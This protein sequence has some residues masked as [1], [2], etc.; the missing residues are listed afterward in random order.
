M[1]SLPTGV[2]F[3]IGKQRYQ[4][5]GLTHS[6]ETPGGYRECKFSLSS[7]DGAQ[8]QWD[9][10]LVIYDSTWSRYP[11]VGHIATVH[12]TGLCFDFTAV[13]ST[14]LRVIKST[15]GAGSPSHPSGVYAGRIYKAG[16]PM[17]STI[18]DALGLCE[19]VFNGA[20]VDPGL[21]YASDSVNVAGYTAEQLWNYVSSLMTGLATPYQWHIRGL[22]GLQV[23]DIAYADAAARYRVKLPEDRIDET[24]DSNQ[25]VTTVAVEYGNDQVY[26]D[27]LPNVSFAGRKLIHDKYVNASSNLNRINEAQGLAGVYLSRLGQFMSTSSTLTLKCN[28][29]IVR[30]VLPVGDS[31][32]WPLWLLE[33]GHGLF[34]ID[35]PIELYPYNEGLKYIIGT[36]YDWDTGVLQ[37]RCGTMAGG[38][39]STVNQIVD[40]NV[41][42]L[43][44]GPYNGPPG[45]SAP[46]ADTDLLP[47]VGP[48]SPGDNSTSGGVPTFVASES[49]GD[50]NV[51]YDKQVHPDLIPDEGLEA[52][53]NIPVDAIGFG[54]GIRVVPGTF[55]EYEVILGNT[56]GKVA[57]TVT[58]EVYKDLGV[59]FGQTLLFT[60]TVTGSN[61]KTAPISPSI[62]L[63]RKDFLLYKV[64]VA[65]TVA[66]WAAISLHA[67]KRF[68][69]LKV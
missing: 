9:D 57:D 21:Q 52:N 45:A 1:T 42:R 18:Q 7:K 2:T 59:G 55:V 4:P 41:N 36:D 14:Q 32:N 69:A 10:K 28:E 67:K 63:G 56:T 51:P 24:Y 38:L 39:E 50:P 64:T 46:L 13:R 11:F 3:T 53:F 34:I 33:S 5:D 30:V 22:A 6:T 16:T 62:A 43:F 66:T 40:Y 17:L 65:G 12:K 35:R 37:L 8:V 23:V 48:E 20:I 61:T 49:Q 68:P 47:T 27:S 44:F 58:I 54:G 31:D 19:N 29:D 25:V 15:S 26:Q 60:I